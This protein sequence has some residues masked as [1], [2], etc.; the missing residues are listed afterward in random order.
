MP[1]SSQLHLVYQ[2][3]RSSTVYHKSAAVRTA[4]LQDCQDQIN[5]ETNT[6]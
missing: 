1:D 5:D 2:A 6:T 4:A 3:A